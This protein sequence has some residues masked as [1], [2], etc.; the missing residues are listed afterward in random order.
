MVAA[1]Y[2][3]GTLEERQDS[4]VVTGHFQLPTEFEVNLGYTRTCF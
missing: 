3:P 4:Q 1:T 2:N